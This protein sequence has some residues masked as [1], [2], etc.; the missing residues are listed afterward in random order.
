M[1]ILFFYSSVT[2]V[3]SGDLIATLLCV[4]GSEEDPCNRQTHPLVAAGA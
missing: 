1:I 4:I 2:A 3:C